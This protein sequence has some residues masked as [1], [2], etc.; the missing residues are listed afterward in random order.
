[1]SFYDYGYSEKSSRYISVGFSEVDI[2]Y[3]KDSY[4][5]WR[6]NDEYIFLQ[7]QTS[8]LRILGE[9]K[10]EFIAIKCS[11]RGNDVYWWR[12]NKRLKFL[13]KLKEKTLFDPHANLK[14][15]NVFFVTLT[16]DTKK[17]SFTEA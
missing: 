13:Y 3:L 15:T 7:K 2:E 6:D 1:M 12:V 17:S 16:Y 8:N 4:L 11:K 5:E 9:V 14:T 10:T